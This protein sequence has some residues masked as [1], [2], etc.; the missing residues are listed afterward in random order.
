MK[1]PSIRWFARRS[2]AAA[3]GLGVMMGLASSSAFSA[4]SSAWTY[5]YYSDAS[6]TEE[7]GRKYCGCVSCGAVIGTQTQYFELEDVMSCS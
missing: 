5:V 6:H 4:R 2:V 1:F 7:V 3:L